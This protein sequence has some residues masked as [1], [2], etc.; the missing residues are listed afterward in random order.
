MQIEQVLEKANA[1]EQDINTYHIELKDE[2]NEVELS[3]DAVVNM[4]YQH[5]LDMHQ[6]W[7]GHAESLKKQKGDVIKRVLLGYAYIVADY[8]IGRQFWT[9]VGVN[10]EIAE[11]EGYNPKPWVEIKNIDFDF[12]MDLVITDFSV[13]DKNDD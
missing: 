3:F 12:E 10:R 13:K 1:G 9:E 4:P 8:C 5:W 2:W 11:R 6:F 7:S